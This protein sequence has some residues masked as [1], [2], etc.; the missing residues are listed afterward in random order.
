MPALVSQRGQVKAPR[1]LGWFVGKLSRQALMQDPT[2]I[3]F[4]TFHGLGSPGHDLPAGEENY[5]LEGAFFEEILD[6]VKDRP[7][8]KITFDDSNL[9]DFA[10]AFPALMKRNLKA[11]FYVVSER[12]DQPWYLT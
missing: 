7:N 9:S 6:Y 12:I 1:L 2:I 10:I 5:W 3:H 8:V 11:S 4:L